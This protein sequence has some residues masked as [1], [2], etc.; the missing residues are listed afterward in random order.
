MNAYEDMSIAEIVDVFDREFKK[1]KKPGYKFVLNS[2]DDCFIEIPGN[3]LTS[4]IVIRLLDRCIVSRNK[5]LK[6]KIEW[7]RIAL[8]LDQIH[9][10][11]FS[12]LKAKISGTAIDKRREGAATY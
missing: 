4:D 9:D 7:S 6:I 1:I 12:I 2:L 8:R 5:L 10:Y 3:R 11:L